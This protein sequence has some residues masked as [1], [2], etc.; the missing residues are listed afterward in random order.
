MSGTQRLSYFFRYCR[1]ICR[2]KSPHSSLT[3]TDRTHMVSCSGLGFC[4]FSLVELAP[5]FSVELSPCIYLYQGQVSLQS[6]CL[7][8]VAHCA[9]VLLNIRTTH[10]GSANQQSF[11]GFSSLISVSNKDPGVPVRYFGF[12]GQPW[13]PLGYLRSTTHPPGQYP[14]GVHGLYVGDEFTD[15]QNILNYKAPTKIIILTMHRTTP[16][17]ICGFG[18]GG[19][20]W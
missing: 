11:L 12:R 8:H 19:I 5:Y 3:G 18:F 20:G 2:R 17:C 1:T 9:V 15:S 16:S 13:E 6:S 14:W 7:C 4:K 10:Y